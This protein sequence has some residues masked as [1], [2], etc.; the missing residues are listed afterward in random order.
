MPILRVRVD[1][2]ALRPAPHGLLDVAEVT[3]RS[4]AHW[5]TGIEY[6]T[7]HCHTAKLWGGWCTGAGTPTVPPEWALLSVE[8]TGAEDGGTYTV[9][10]AVTVDREPRRQV[11]LTL[12]TSEDDDSRTTRTG[13]AA[14][15]FTDEAP[16]AG[17][18]IV[19]DVLTGV[20]G[21]YGVSQADDGTID[22]T[23]VVAGS[24]LILAVPV[25]AVPAGCEA[26]TLDFTVSANATAGVDV[27]VSVT[28]TV[29]DE[30]SITVA[31][32]RLVIG[33]GATSGSL[34]IPTGV[35]A[36]TWPISVRDVASS[37]FASGW[38]YLDEDTAGAATLMVTSCPAK[39]IV[40]PPWRTMFGT[41]WTI[42]AEVICKAVAF[43]EA[44]QAA[45]EALALA[46]RK[47]VE[48]TWWDQA[49]DEA[50][51]LASGI[52]LVAAIAE[53]E[54]YIATNYNGLGLI[55]VPDYLA[56]YLS[57]DDIASGAGG[58]ELRTLRG[59]PIVIGQGYPRQGDATGAGVA[60]MATGQVELLHSPVETVE[61]FDRRTNDLVAVAEQTWVSANDCLQPAVVYVDLTVT[62]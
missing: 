51:V 8:L 3:E 19:T 25:V 24:Q 54:H 30:L 49:F 22:E 58:G 55:H 43:E 46:G 32:H 18:L 12:V 34:T 10:A 41:P 35:G 15:E 4:D 44:S 16:I 47:A 38:I 17:D 20:S 9:A 1:P 23:A 40:S 26:V 45:S 42:Y 52:D 48:S 56:S 11:R 13:D 57:A 53:L 27:A 39:E 62:R 37:S 61:A 21:R 28:G 29:I 60:V 59:T 2:P 6:D 50:R 5:R 36:G 33:Q 14:V 31:G 7:N